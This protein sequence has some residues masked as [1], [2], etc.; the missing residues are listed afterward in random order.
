MDGRGVI[1]GD[2]VYVPLRDRIEVFHAQRPGEKAPHPIALAAL[3]P[4]VTGGHLIVCDTHL[5]V[6]GTDAIYGFELSR[7]L[8][9]YRPAPP[10]LHSDLAGPIRAN[11]GDV[12]GWWC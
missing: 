6:V 11:G 2:Y 10:K 9:S 1:V 3:H 5:L 7:P 12:F 8:S 4:G